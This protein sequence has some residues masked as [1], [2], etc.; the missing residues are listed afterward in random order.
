MEKKEKERAEG[1]GRRRER[2]AGTRIRKIMKNKKTKKKIKQKGDK[3]KNN[4]KNKNE[5]TKKDQTNRHTHRQTKHTQGYTW[6]D[7]GVVNHTHKA[8]TSVATD[9]KSLVIHAFI[10]D[11]TMIYC[12]PKQSFISNTYRTF[13]INVSATIRICLLFV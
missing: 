3:K 1:G 12:N 5:K 6:Q 13:L 10:W 4:N 11:Y 2:G 8:H 9:I 7:P